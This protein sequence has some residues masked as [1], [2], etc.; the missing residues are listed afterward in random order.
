MT[1]A[2]ASILDLEIPGGWTERQVEL[3]GRWLSLLV[4]AAP[5]EFLNQLDE[6]RLDEL[7]RLRSDPYWAQVWT[8]ARPLANAVA[9]QASVWPAGVRVLELGCGAGLVGLA[10]AASGCDVLFTDYVP[11]AVELAL[12]NARRNGLTANGRSLD[13]RAPWEERFPVIVG[14]DILYDSSLHGSLIGVFQLMLGP[15]GEIWLGDPGR[16]AASTFLD[17]AAHA[18]FSPQLFDA[19]SRPLAKPQCGQFQ[20]IVLRRLRPE[21]PP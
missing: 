9:A 4:P 6:A 11:E 2:R 16:S 5:D 3:A 14:S 19:D 17:R 12:E 7:P 18:G 8:A 15:S 1:S 13:W 20:R 10:A 21:S